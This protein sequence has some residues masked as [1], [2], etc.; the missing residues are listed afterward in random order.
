MYWENV[1]ACATYCSDCGRLAVSCLDDGGEVL[2]KLVSMKHMRN[3][4]IIAD[5]YTTEA[6]K[7]IELNKEFYGEKFNENSMLWFREMVCGDCLKK[8]LSEKPGI[9]IIKFDASRGEYIYDDILVANSENPLV[10]FVDFIGACQEQLNWMIE[11]C[12]DALVEQLNQELLKEISGESYETLI[13]TAHYGIKKE[14]FRLLEMF[15]YQAMPSILGYLYAIL[16]YSDE[17]KQLE[18][19][20]KINYRKMKNIIDKYPN[21]LSGYF[22]EED[23]T[24]IRIGYMIHNVEFN[25]GTYSANE[26]HNPSNVRFYSGLYETD[27]LSIKEIIHRQPELCFEWDDES[28]ETFRKRLVRKLQN[29]NQLFLREA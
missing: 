4:P 17:Y 3:E 21:N 24:N 27:M 11:D 19:Q 8:Q 1:V 15:S 13:S 28:I 29:M 20:R 6:E 26:I 22:A 5:L 9:N 2:A 18:S 25:L 23:L 14:K 10:D 7:Q 12:A 16:E